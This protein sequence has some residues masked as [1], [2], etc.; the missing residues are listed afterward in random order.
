MDGEKKKRNLFPL[1]LV[2]GIVVVIWAIASQPNN[3]PNARV[4]D[5]TSTS[6]Y[7][8][9]AVKVLA[10]DAIKE[11]DFVLDAAVAQ[12][13]G[14]LNLAIIVRNAVNESYARELGDSF[15]RMVVTALKDGQPG[16]EI[17]KTGFDYMVGI[18]TTD[19]ETVSLGAKVSIARWITW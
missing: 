5:R 9:T 12:K 18:Y 2:I 14:K 13:G 4:N 8:E 16:V 6:K 10:I 7:D 11:R 1:Y 15:V 3:I 17:G 19:K